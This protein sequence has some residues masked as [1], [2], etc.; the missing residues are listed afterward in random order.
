MPDLRPAAAGG[1]GRR[2]LLWPA[3][4]ALAAFA[5]LV[6]LGTWQ[7]QRRAWKD[8]LLQRVEARI[9]APPAPLPPP[10][11]FAGLTREAD[12]YRRVAVRG[13]FDHGR[14]ALVFTVRGTDAPGPLKGQGFLVVTPLMRADGPPVLVNRGFVPLDRRDPATRAAGQVA[15]EVEVTGLLRLPEEASWFVPAN[16]A[17]RRA[18]YRM[19]PAEIAAAVGLAGAAPFLV[20]ADAAP[21][22]GGLPEGGGTR[23]AFPNR[24]LEYALTWYGLAGA[25]AGVCAALLWSRRRRRAA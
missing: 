2:G 10:A 17:A 18:F 11:A 21:V 20:D 6:G 14:E 1:G 22:P 13:T 24:H 16:D 5:V 4:V 12:E 25:L 7:L 9:H 3:L 15:G 23:I 8:A 19:D